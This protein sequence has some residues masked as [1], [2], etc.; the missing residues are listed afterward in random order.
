MLFKCSR[1]PLCF[2]WILD[3]HG[4]QSEEEEEEER[5]EIGGWRRGN[6]DVLATWKADKNPSIVSLLLPTSSTECFQRVLPI[7]TS[8]VR[9]SN[10]LIS[11]QEARRTVGSI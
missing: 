4:K 3:F 5:A 2:A 7:Q 11:I 9:R 6:E 10:F 1:G 8:L